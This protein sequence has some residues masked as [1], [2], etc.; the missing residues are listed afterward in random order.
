MRFR[1]HRQTAAHLHRY[2]LYPIIRWSRDNMER[3]DTSLSKDL[4]SQ[5]KERM[6]RNHDVMDI[7][8]SIM[9]VGT[10][11]WPLHVPN[12]FIVPPEIRP[13][14]DQFSKYYKTKHSGRKLTW[15][16]NYS[17][18]ELRTTYLN[19]KYVLMTSSYQMAVLLQYNDHDTLSLDEVATATAISKSILVPV[20]SLLVRGKILLCVEGDH[21]C[22]N[23][24]MFRARMLIGLLPCAYDCMQISSRQRFASI[25]TD[26]SRQR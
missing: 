26:R 3:T 22:L 18:N 21:Y 4:T 16:W 7:N 15:L 17:R 14:Y 5:F 1:L 13:V 25:S 2:A 8:F 12:N 24:S 19:K 11:L 6:R 10:N 20:L 23:F 9:I